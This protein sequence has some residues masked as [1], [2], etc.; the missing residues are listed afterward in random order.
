MLVR[1]LWRSKGT[2]MNKSKPSAGSTA[3][4]EKKSRAPRAA[5]HYHTGNEEIAKV[6]QDEDRRVPGSNPTAGPVPNSKKAATRG[7]A[8][9]KSARGQAYPESKVDTSNHE[10]MRSETDGT[11]YMKAHGSKRTIANTSSFG[12]KRYEA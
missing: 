1:A 2:V 11:K 4:A 12:G 6:S 10:K 9:H 5:G 8:D 3:H 7:F